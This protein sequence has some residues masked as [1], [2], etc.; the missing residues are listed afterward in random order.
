MDYGIQ[1]T[2]EEVAIERQFNED[3]MRLLERAILNSKLFRTDR[4][5][6]LM[7]KLRGGASP[8][9]RVN[10]KTAFVGDAHLTPQ[11]KKALGL[12]TRMK[13]SRD[14]IDYFRPESLRAIEP[15]SALADM[16][17]AAFHSVSRQKDLNKFRKLGFVKQV[18]IAF[19]GGDSCSEVH[20]LKKTYGL[21]SVSGVASGRL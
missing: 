2:E 19:A 16:H 1:M 9:G 8:F 3:V 6:D 11:E 12:N 20:R 7:S 5:P 4:V 13:Y 14:F 15:K 10:T 17:L 21:D 18:T